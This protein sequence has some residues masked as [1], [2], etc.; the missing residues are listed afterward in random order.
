M[1]EYAAAAREGGLDFLVFLEGFATLDPEKLAR[2]RRACAKHSGTDLLLLPGYRID[3]N[4]D[5]RKA[6][7]CANNGMRR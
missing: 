4:T 2:L 3:T 5:S 7:Y 1:A 6:D